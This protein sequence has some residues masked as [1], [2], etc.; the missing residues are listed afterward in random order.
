MDLKSF[1][2]A[3]EQIADEK[4]IA[5]DRIIETIELALA[6]A[7]KRDYGKRG[8]IIRAALEPSSGDILMK[9]I[10]IA[11]DETM[12]KSEE[13]VRREEEERDETKKSAGGGESAGQL[14]AADVGESDLETPQEMEG[15]RKVRFNPEKHLMIDDARAIK[16]DVNPGDE[17]EF[18]LPYHESY[19]RIAAQ[20]AKQVIIQRVREAERE[21]V[22]GE[23]KT[24]EGEI[25]SGIIQR[26]EG[27]N[28]YVDLGRTVAV[29]PAEEQIA[30]E[31]YYPGTR[32]KFLLHMVERNPRGPG[33]FLSRSHPRFLKKLFE[34]EVP[35][36]STGAVEIKN[37]A[38]EAG[39]RS[40]VAVS[41]NEKGVDPVG[42]LVG[43]K[44]VRV[45]T[46]IQEL[47]GEKIDVIEWSEETNQFIAHALSPAK[48]IEVQVDDKRRDAFVT[49]PEDQLSLAIGKGGQNVR[50]A[51]K[52]TGWR[53]DVRA[54]Q[55]VAEAAAIPE[56]V[57]PDASVEESAAPDENPSRNQ[58][59]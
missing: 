13:E 55:A 16:P 36:I 32:M 7:Y 4:G 11:V 58:P 5:K 57:S 8:Q 49:V 30:S 20:T 44:G 14:T 40:K 2:Q 3:I 37:V 17:I 46:V 59:S 9:Q 39:S 50:L 56:E 48:V 15:E 38:R 1:T 19:G 53:I 12:I 43:Q 42:S 25:V 27:R 31:R 52:L 33:M 22:F 18:D 34:I 47:G 10:K 41:S 28:V 21:A 45:T 51:A 6:A 24:R 26:I 29:L 23:Y 35:E 54:P